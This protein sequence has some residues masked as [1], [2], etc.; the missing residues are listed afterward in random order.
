M[1]E[2]KVLEIHDAR[3]LVWRLQSISDHQARNTPQSRFGTRRS[4]SDYA[5]GLVDHALR[6]ARGLFRQ[7]SDHNFR[8]C[9]KA[10]TSP[11]SK[12]GDY[13]GTMH[14]SVHLSIQFPR[15]S[16]FKTLASR[17]YVTYS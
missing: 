1:T 3:G 15:R 8:P 10:H 7:L 14:L 6:C 11:S 2:K 4:L 9:Y 17:A 12:L 13:I 16:I 5:R